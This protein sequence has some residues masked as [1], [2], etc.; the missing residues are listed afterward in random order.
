MGEDRPQKLSAE[1]LLERARKGGEGA[2]LAA[3]RAAVLAERADPDLARDALRLVANLEPLDPQPRLAL[4]RLAAEQGDLAAAIKEAEAVLAEAI[5]Q[6]ARARAAF[7][8]G[9]IARIQGQS[10][11]ARAAYTTTLRI[12]D[13]LLAAHR[14]D[15]AAA[16]WYARAR[17][18]LAELDAGRRVWPRAHRR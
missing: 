8:L 5:D 15:V 18:R 14:S 7:I 1:A 4:A 6:A 2:A 10:D 17:G 9:E 16:R 13:E 3:R 12:E 11:R